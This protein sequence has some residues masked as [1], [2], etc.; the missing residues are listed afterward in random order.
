M[1]G[2]L[3]NGGDEMLRIAAAVLAQ[4]GAQ[5]WLVGG[6]V[7][8]LKLGCDSPDI[9]LAVTG[10]AAAIA[11]A[12]ARGLGLPWF[13]LSERHGAYRVVGRDAHVDVAAC[14]GRR[15]PR[16]PGRTRFHRQRHG[17]ASRRTGTPLA[18]SWTPSEAWPIL[19][20]GD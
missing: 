20:P 9:D 17:H 10:D 2:T 5:G 19:G 11:R 6:S 12:V 8:D 18:T 4:H 14:K 3:T 7:R 15:Y 13:A 1:P 16:R